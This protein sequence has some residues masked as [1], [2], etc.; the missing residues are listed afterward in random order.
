[1]EELMNV[2]RS[3]KQSFLEN[4]EIVMKE[5]GTDFKKQYEEVTSQIE[6]M[7]KMLESKD[8]KDYERM[9]LKG[10]IAALEEERREMKSQI[11]ARIRRKET[12][13]EAM[14][15][16]VEQQLRTYEKL[17]EEMENGCVDDLNRSLLHPNAMCV[18]WSFNWGE[19]MFMGSNTTSDIINTTT[20]TTTI[21]F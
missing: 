21:I 8:L 9:N 12:G 1:M 20:T 15:E 13:S 19:Y 7:K 16:E 2:L 10:D 14:N 5:M 11:N 17:E 3:Q 6:E 18:S 4:R